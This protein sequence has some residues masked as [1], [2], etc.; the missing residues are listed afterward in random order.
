MSL[1]S[2]ARLS[3]FFLMI[4]RPPR[5][6]LF[7][8]TTLFRS[9]L[10]PREIPA[11]VISLAALALLLLP[12]PALLSGRG[13]RRLKA[14]VEERPLRAMALPAALLLP[15][16]LYWSVPGNATPAGG[17]DLLTYVLVPSALAGLLPRGRTRAGG[18]ALVV[19][20]IWLP[21][22]LRLLSASFPWPHGG[23]GTFLVRSEEH[24]SEL[25]SLAYLV[26]RLLL[27]K[28]KKDTYN[29]ENNTYQKTYLHNLFLLYL[30]TSS[31]L[32]IPMHLV[33][34]SMCCTCSVVITFQLVAH[35]HLRN[36]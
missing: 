35:I 21:V 28:K 23:A 18:D 3:F 2:S 29:T 34:I 11:L 20:S 25:Q 12:L 13:L 26:C 6:T 14:W 27:E 15:C 10:P 8:S 5:S 33:T 16:L 32:V 22:E 30:I 4:R 24:T 7:P 1:V 36:I 31:D 9:G 19:L 17:V